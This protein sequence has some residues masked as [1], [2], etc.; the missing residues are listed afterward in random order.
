MYAIGVTGSKSRIH[1]LCF[2][3]DTFEVE[4]IKYVLVLVKH[5]RQVEEGYKT[6][7]LHLQ[8]YYIRKNEDAHFVH[9]V[10]NIAACREKCC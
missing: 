1:N 6:Y 4:S 8:Y 2:G 3:A 7:K 5:T 10:S 9:E